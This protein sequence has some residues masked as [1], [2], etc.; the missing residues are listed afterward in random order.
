MEGAMVG[1]KPLDEDALLTAAR[2]RADDFAAFYRHF[3]RPVLRFFMRAAGRP[4]LAADLTAETFASALESVSSY[5]PARGRADQ[6]LFGIARNVLATSYR[7]GRVDAAARE[8]LGLPKLFLDD[9]ATETI[10]RLSSREDQATLALAELRGSSEKRSKPA[11][12][13]SATTRRSLANFS[14]R[15]PWCA[16]GSAADSVPYEHDWQVNDD[17]PPPT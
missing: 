16:N 7:R 8:R 13:T 4:D 12:S 9:H 6:W 15:R 11:S 5:D 17:D 2:T 1:S 10:S 3:E 14:A